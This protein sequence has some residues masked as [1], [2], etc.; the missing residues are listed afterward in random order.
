MS[1]A[2]RPC[3]SRVRH[4]LHAPVGVREEVLQP[5]AQVVQTRLAVGREQDAVLGALAVAGE[6]E[7][8]LAA[9]A[10]Q[11]VALR[12]AERPLLSARTSSPIGVSMM[13]PS[14][15]GGSTKWSHEYTSPL[16]S[17]ATPSP[18]VGRR[19]HSDE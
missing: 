1:P 3:S 14:R 13:L 12:L 15:C 5:L 11:R 4:H 17:S 10:R 6:Q 16:C 9:V 8:A 2:S 7:L 19:T 18:Q